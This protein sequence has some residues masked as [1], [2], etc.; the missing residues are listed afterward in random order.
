MKSRPGGGLL[1]GNC[2]NCGAAVGQ[3]NQ[4]A[5][6]EHCEAVLRSGQFDWVLVEITQASEYVP[7][8]DSMIA[9][10]T[11]VQAIDPDF[12]VTHLEDPGRR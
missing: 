6:C 12:T 10:E 2:P 9:G 11:Q 5:V 1:E 4:S 3:L 7:G 8:V